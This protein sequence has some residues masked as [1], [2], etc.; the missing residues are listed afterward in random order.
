MLL[1]K[2]DFGEL[3]CTIVSIKWAYRG[4]D[5]NVALQRT[6]IKVNGPQTCTFLFVF[7][8]RPFCEWDYC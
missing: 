2:N 4:M 8:V 6:N 1:E 7:V 3:R 5:G